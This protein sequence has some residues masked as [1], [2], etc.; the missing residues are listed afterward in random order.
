VILKVF[1]DWVGFLRLVG[2]LIFCE[3]HLLFW[4]RK[5]SVLGARELDDR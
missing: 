5:Q 1:L 2:F 3:L 4:F